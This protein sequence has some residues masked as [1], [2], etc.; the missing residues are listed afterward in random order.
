M[1]SKTSQTYQDDDHRLMWM[2]FECPYISESVL[3]IFD[4]SRVS[5]TCSGQMEG[6]CEVGEVGW[7]KLGARHCVAKVCKAMYSTPW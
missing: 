1:F 3:V 5:P 4:R 2:G 6:G 7:L